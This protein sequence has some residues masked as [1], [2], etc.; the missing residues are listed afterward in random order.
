MRRAPFLFFAAALFAQGLARA[1]GPVAVTSGEHD[2]YSRIVVSGGAKSAAVDPD[3]REILITLSED[4]GAVDLSGID[5]AHKPKRV[6]GAAL[7]GGSIIRIKLNCD[8]AVETSRL[9][10]GRLVVDV[11][12]TNKSEPPAAADEDKT[13][14]APQASAT[15]VAAPT[16]EKATDPAQTP[17]AAEDASLDEA[18]ERM[19]KLLRRA[20]DDGLVTIRGGSGGGAVIAAAPPQETPA[21]APPSPPKKDQPCLPDGAFSIDGAAFEDKPLVAIAD[22]QAKLTSAAPGEQPEIVKKLADGYLSIAF[23]DEA[24]SLLTGNGM[25]ASLAGDMARAVA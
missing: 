7:I 21:E 8:C 18:R 19:I 2:G 25:D 23:G 1:A 16:P 3:Q 15:P 24:L 9:A 12:D 5:A 17:S 6:D 4:A 22:L 20:A 10:D 13:S 14:G 11:S